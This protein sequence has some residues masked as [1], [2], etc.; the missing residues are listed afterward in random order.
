MSATS[1]AA[2]QMDRVIALARAHLLS[3][4][5]PEG[6]WAECFDTGVMADAQTLVSL[7]LVGERDPSWTDPLIYRLQAL[8]RDNGAW[9]VHP[10]DQ[11]DLSTTVEC[12]Y[13]LH[14]YQAWPTPGAEQAARAFIASQGGLRRCR[15]LTKVFLAIGGE[16]PWSAL[17]SP[18]VYAW[19]F[20]PRS[21]VRITD[22]V[23]FT[24][25]HV[26]PML[27]LAARRYVAPGRRA[28]V[29]ATAVSAEATPSP[30]GRRGQ[31]RG[32][33]RTGRWFTRCLRWLLRQREPDGT[34]AGYHSSS[35]LLLFVYLALGRSRAHPGVRRVLASMRRNL[36]IDPLTGC[37]HQQT[38]N[39]HV[40]N[41]ALAVRALTAA[42]VPLDD[43]HLAKAVAFL[44]AHQQRRRTQRSGIDRSGGWAF[45]DNNTTHPDT[46]DTVAC[47][48]A[49]SPYRRMYPRAWT[50]GVAWL[51][52][53]QNRD[54]G[55]SAFEKDCSRR[56]LEWIP[57]NDMRRTMTDPSTPDITGRVTAFLLRDGGYPAAHPQ[58]QRAIRWLLRHQERDG[59]WFGRW[60]STYIY[61]TWCAVQALAASPDV[62][63][64]PALERAANWLLSIQHGD[65]SFGES[66]TSDLS[67]HYVDLLSGTP[68]HTA[69]AL[70][71]LTHLYQAALVPLDRHRLWGA[72]VQAASWLQAHV[73][74]DGTW[75]ETVPTGSAFPGDLHIRYH[76]YPKVWPLLALCRFDKIS[77]ARAKR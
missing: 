66:C 75:S 62:A 61:G 60:G 74:P 69:W 15:N 41:T 45:S 16:V 28:R 32:R 46:D 24:R 76:L 2:V 14:L 49:L 55:W 19:L 34:L 70:D 25:L 17:P 18:R 33:R 1:G 53:M 65:G 23:C 48:E 3:R 63:H 57:A 54:G 27:L 73:E 50:E 64:A 38:C 21:P 36:L 68:T 56:W 31:T 10:E 9:G 29:F 39:A 12:A 20:A 77:C 26:A 22:L 40:W 58:V 42:G 67:G 13:A 52:R 51:L 6:Y 8:Q 11:G 5:H 37:G 35:W 7:A 43:P 44:D 72:M 71:A 47:L 59:S 4:Q 30:D